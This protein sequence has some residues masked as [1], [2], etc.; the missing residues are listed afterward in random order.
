MPGAMV[1]QAF[2]GGFHACCSRSSRVS[3]LFCF[4]QQ[5]Q[6]PQAPGFILRFAQ[7]LPLALDVFTPDETLHGRTPCPR[8]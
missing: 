8:P 2:S 4:T 3:V 6:D 1:A 5:F 7:Q